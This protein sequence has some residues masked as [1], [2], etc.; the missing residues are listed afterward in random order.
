MNWLAHLRLSPPDPL[1]RLGNL[2]GDF[3]RGVDVARLHPGLQRG[4]ALHRALDRFVDA[5]PIAVRARQRLQPPF[6]RFGGV[7][8]DVWFDHF[9]A[10]DW[11]RFGGGASLP[12]FL[13]GVHGDL[14][15]HHELLPPDLQ[16]AAP[17]FTTAGWLEGYASVAGIDRVLALMAQRFARPSPLARGGEP[18]RH[19]YDALASDFAALWP[20]LTACVAAAA[21]AS[22]SR[23]A[24]PA[25]P[26]TVRMD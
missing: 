22:A 2:A 12:S 23:A 17:R 6:R 18:L 21:A 11:E 4:I 3:V 8:V 15:A 25:V 7:L 5:H 10:R 26:R 20:E 24:P 14:R 19:H 1:V 9:L 16:R 13:A